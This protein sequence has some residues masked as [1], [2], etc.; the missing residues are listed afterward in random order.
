MINAADYE[1]KFANKTGGGPAT[2]PQ[3]LQ[4]L[5]APGVKGRAGVVVATTPNKEGQ[6]PVGTPI[7]EGVV[8]TQHVGRG[9]PTM[10]VVPPRAQGGP[11]APQV[12]VVPPQEGA[13][14]TIGTF[15][16]RPGAAGATQSV[17]TSR[18]NPLDGAIPLGEEPKIEPETL[19]STKKREKL[20]LAQLILTHVWELGGEKSAE[21]QK[22][23]GRSEQT[24]KNWLKNPGAIPLECVTKFLGRHRELEVQI[25][26]ELEPHFAANGAQG[27]SQSLPNRGKTSCMICAPILGQPTLPFMWTVCYLLKKY[28]MGLDI[29]ADTAIWRSRNMLAQRFLRSNCTWSLWLDSDM[30]APIANKEWYRW[31]TRSEVIPDEHANYDVFAR[32]LTHGKPIAGGVYASRQMHGNLVIQPDIRPRHHEDKLLANEIRKG[33]ARGLAGVDWVGFGCVLVHRE[34]FIELQRAF[35]Q[36]APQSEFAP[37]RFFQPEG[38]EGEDEAFC[39]RARA[40]SIPV[41]LDT[42][43]VCG[44]IGNMCYM[45]EHTRPVPA[46]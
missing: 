46:L 12:A 25:Q 4:D 5:Y 32:L 8:I 7:P 23:Y 14:T 41:W 30:A 19:A 17:I 22:F 40:C 37:W 21:A 18:V 26:E 16:E 29:Q 28:E 45:P 43:L 38:D 24:M 1:S 36:L 34:V 27:W 31:L 13:R 11:P 39:K 2:Q 44:H 6:I 15:V 33:T 9:L 42:Q 20:D 10:Q 3:P 35:P